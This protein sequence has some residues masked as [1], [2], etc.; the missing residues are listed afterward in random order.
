MNTIVRLLCRSNRRL[1]GLFDQLFDLVPDL[2]SLLLSDQ[3]S[4]FDRYVIRYN[5]TCYALEKHHLIRGLIETIAQLSATPCVGT[6]LKRV[7]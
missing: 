7:D 6:V 4:E 2:D 3:W 1:S 5:Y